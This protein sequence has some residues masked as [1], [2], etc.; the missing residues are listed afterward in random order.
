[1]W[2][3]RLYVGGI[4]PHG[5]KRVKQMT[6]NL[7]ASGGGVLDDPWRDRRIRRQILFSNQSTGIPQGV[8]SSL[9]SPMGRGE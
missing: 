9:I 5:G 4:P 6:G 7:I 2:E 1:V 3:G 8:L